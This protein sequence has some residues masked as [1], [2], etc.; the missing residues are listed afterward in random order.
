MEQ[1]P[2]TKIIFT[3]FGK[4]AIEMKHE[5]L[6]QKVSELGKKFCPDISV[7]V[8]LDNS[9][10]GIPSKKIAKPIFNREETL[11]NYLGSKRQF[12]NAILKYIPKDT[13]TLF[14]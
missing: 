3:H 5:K 7:E 10:F 8:A 6:V 9:T 11:S 2:M 1:A 13:K 4:E 12:V 14:D